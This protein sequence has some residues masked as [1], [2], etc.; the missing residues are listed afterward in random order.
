MPILC[1]VFHYGADE[2]SYKYIFMYVCIYLRMHKSRHF[3]E[4]M[5][6]QTWKHT[7]NVIDRN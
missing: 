3:Y 6:E 5:Y 2:I 1:V 7:S 4:L